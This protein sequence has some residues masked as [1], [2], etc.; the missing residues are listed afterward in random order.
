MYISTKETPGSEVKV[1]DRR[2]AIGEFAKIYTSYQLGGTNYFNGK[3]EN[4]GIY[5]HFQISDCD[6]HSERTMLMGGDSFK[7]FHKAL[8]RKSQKSINEADAFIFEN[9]DEIYKLYRENKRDELIDLIQ[10]VHF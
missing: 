8:N 9:K 6:E 3:N 4:R 10:S 1:T 7:I 5:I 2:E